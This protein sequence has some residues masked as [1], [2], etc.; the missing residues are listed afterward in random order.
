MIWLGLAVGTFFVLFIHEIGHLLAA[1][2][3]GVRVVSCSIGLGPK[4]IAFED[5]WRTQ[6]TLG[7]LPLG[8]SVGM[9]ND[10]TSA[11]PL[12][13]IAESDVLS[14]RSVKQQA[15]LFLAGPTFSLLLGMSLIAIA[16]S[17]SG[18]LILQGWNTNDGVLIASLL[19]GLS[20]LIGVFDL[21]PFPPL[22]GGKLLLLLIEANRSKPVSQHTQHTLSDIGMMLI[23]FATLVIMLGAFWLFLHM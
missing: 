18:Q 10:T 2:W 12:H 13:P 19:G 23:N 22:D 20:I 14:D 16:H 5:R 1:R 6:W 8:G 21:L 11:R 4:L 9:W 7:M 15:A 3:L 17:W